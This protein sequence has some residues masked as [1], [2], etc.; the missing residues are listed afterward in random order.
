M[1]SST[2]NYARVWDGRL[3]VAAER[4]VEIRRLAG[5]AR[6]LPRDQQAALKAL[7]V[8]ARPALPLVVGEGCPLLG[9]LAGVR[10]RPLA[11]ARLLAACGAVTREPA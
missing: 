5:M 4:P 7:P 10:V 11:H 2:N 1:S 3:E 8:G 6:Q 9:D